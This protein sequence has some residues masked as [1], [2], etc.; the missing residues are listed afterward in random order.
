MAERTELLGATLVRCAPRRNRHR[1]ARTLA[2][3]VCGGLGLVLLVV[4]LVML[5]LCV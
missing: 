2:L 1:S 3:D 4:A 5:A